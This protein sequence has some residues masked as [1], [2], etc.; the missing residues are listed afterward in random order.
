MSEPDTHAIYKV[1]PDDHRETDQG[2]SVVLPGQ[3][4]VHRLACADCDVRVDK[5]VD[6]ADH[7]QADP[8]MIV[9][10]YLSG[11]PVHD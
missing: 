6:D 3:E 8:M 5:A 10:H 1:K 2:R 4:R 7:R 9:Q 11:I